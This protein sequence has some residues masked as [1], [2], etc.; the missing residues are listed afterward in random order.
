[1]NLLV[2]GIALVAFA[3]QGHFKW[4]SVWPFLITSIPASYIG[5]TQPMKEEIYFLILAAV[6]IF[7]AVRLLL[8][9]PAER[10]TQKDINVSL[11]LV[12]GF[13]IGL[14]SGVIGVGGGI[15]LSPVLILLAWAGAK[16]TAA[17]SALFILVNSG[18]GIVG[19]LV[20]ERYEPVN[21]VPLLLAALIGAIIGARFGAEKF[22]PMVVQRLLAV[23]LVIAA[24]KMVILY[25]PSLMA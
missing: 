19:R 6:L 11:A 25:A 2:A 4:R 12:I 13:C 15:F 14:L 10:E 16:E 24:A 7:A 17:A 8:P 3:K 1:M 5:G 18:A 20:T 21:L 9:R 22:K 23:V